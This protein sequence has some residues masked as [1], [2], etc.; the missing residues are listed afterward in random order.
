MRKKHKQV[1]E[2]LAK[3]QDGLLETLDESLLKEYSSKLEAGMK[4]FGKNDNKFGIIKQHFLGT[5]IS[6]DGSQLKV[7]Q[8]QLTRRIDGIQAYFAKPIIALDVFR[9]I[10]TG[11]LEKQWKEI[12]K[13]STLQ[14][15]DYKDIKDIIIKMFTESDK[16]SDYATKHNIIVRIYT[17]Q[18][19]N[20][21]IQ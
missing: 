5:D 14:N 16:V 17:K 6:L 4:V 13:S 9:R 1:I 19:I 15:V 10:E 18:F 2:S 8:S 11:V 7:Y 3:I 12:G 21:F 20:L